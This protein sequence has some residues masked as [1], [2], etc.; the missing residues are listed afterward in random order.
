MIHKK[1][2]EQKIKLYK[3]ICYLYPILNFFE[4]IHDKYIFDLKED[5]T[6][7]FRNAFFT[8]F[9]KLI[10]KFQKETD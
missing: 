4:N 5:L 10:L 3:E 9:Y 1:E 6:L 8:K 2:Y 7:I